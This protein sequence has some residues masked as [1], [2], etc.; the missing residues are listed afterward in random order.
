M[1]RRAV[2]H[3]DFFEGFYEWLDSEQGEASLE[4]LDAVAQAL[5][6]ADVD[7]ETRRIVWPD[8]KRLTIDRTAQR[9]HKLSG[10]DLRAITSHVIGWLEMNFEPA[11]LDEK[12]MEL[13]EA[14]IQDWIE[15][16]QAENVE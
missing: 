8:G 6:G 3:D 2:P 9:I 12:Q 13:F 1:K 5:Q 15:E 16:Y 11:G 7:I 4:A 14:Q 10:A